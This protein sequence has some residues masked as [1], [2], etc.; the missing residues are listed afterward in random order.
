M[1]SITVDEARRILWEQ[2]TPGPVTHL[3]LHEAMGKVLAEDLRTDRSFPPFD[4]MAMDGYAVRSA[5]TEGASAEN[6]VRLEVIGEAR[7]GRRFDGKLARGQAVRAMTGAPLPA[8]AD[9]VVPVEDTAGWDEHEARIHRPVREGENIA[10][11]GEDLNEGATILGRG[12]RLG[13]RHIPVLA[14]AGWSMVPVVAPP[15]AAVLS[16]GDELVDIADTPTPAQIRESN[17]PCVVASLA[18][19]GIECEELGHVQDDR[20]T[21]RR[22]VDDALSHYELLVLSGGVSMGERDVVKE[23]LEDAGVRLHFTSLK[24]RPGH[25]AVFGTHPGGMVFALPGN[26]VSVFVSLRVVYSAGLARRLG[27]PSAPGPRGWGILD[28]DFNRNT[29]RDMYLP[30]SLH[31]TQEPSLPL[32]R[33]TGYHGSGDFTALAAADAL[34]CLEGERRQWPRGTAVP[35]LRLDPMHSV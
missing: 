26:P 1:A 29:D 9:A 16:T 19:W 17:G 5:D 15:S 10:H 3:P 21:L 6:P 18:E 14:A 27:H 7:A 12:T 32:L 22:A 33:S 2:I 4:R 24:V 23:V 20:D 13:T 35:I 25:P 31:A 34:A 8:G 30:V 28:F 11:R